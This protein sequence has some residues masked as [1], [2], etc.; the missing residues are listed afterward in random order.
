MPLLHDARC[1][2]CDSGLPLKVLWE[3]SRSSQYDLVTKSG[4]LRGRIG[5]VCPG[6]GVKLGV[7]QTRIRVFVLLLWVVAFGGAWFVG[8]WMR[9]SRVVLNQVSQVLGFVAFVSTLFVLQKYCI[10]H[11]A[12]VR[13]AGAGE[14]LGFPLSGAYA[15][16]SDSQDTQLAAKAVSDQSSERRGQVDGNS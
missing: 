14:Q 5:I 4:V 3:F 8:E 15:N 7:V 11:L 2:Q 9:H 6:C 12:Q 13:L 10:P 16:R 1:P